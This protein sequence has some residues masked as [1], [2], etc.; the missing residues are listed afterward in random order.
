MRNFLSDGQI[1]AATDE[2][3]ENVLKFCIN[4]YP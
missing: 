2:F 4:H 3:G 1:V